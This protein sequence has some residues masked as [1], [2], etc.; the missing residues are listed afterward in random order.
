MILPVVVL[1]VIAYFRTTSGSSTTWFDDFNLTITRGNTELTY[2]ADV[3]SYS[4]YYAFGMQMPGRYANDGYRYGFGGHEKDDEIK[5]SGNHYSFGDYGYDPRLGRRW[6]VDPLANE[7]PGTSPYSY[8][9][10]NPILLK[11]PDGKLPIIPFLLKAGAAG[12]TD[13]LLQ[14]GMNYLLDDDV[15]TIGQAFEKVDWVDVSFSAAQGAL[16]WSVPGGKFGKAAAAATG[17]V[18]LN[19]T[20]AA[21]SG[22]DYSVEQAT[23]DFF[24][25]FF[26]QLTAEGVGELLSSKKA[27]EKLGGIIGQE[28]LDNILHRFDTRS[29]DQ[30]NAGGGFESWGNDMN[31][32]DHATGKN[33]KNKTS[34][35][36]STSMTKEGAV[37]Y[38]GGRKGYLYKIQN[39][40]SGIDV[41]KK[42]G[43][44]SPFPQEQ[45]IV[46]PNK[47]PKENIISSEPL[48]K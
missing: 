27:R 31:L 15:E 29:P 5:G 35:Y 12:A 40:G 38:A 42:L 19:A 17:D 47:I 6:N 16:P 10:N 8:A 28:K 32:M 2:T 7:M 46:I 34:G 21:L 11:D 1:E 37:N 25:G 45:E 30:I 23:A 18:L 20:K 44:K 33:I 3:K 4:D 41:N 36:V 22:E 24:V 14:V 9:Y 43:S 39:P 48:N 13:M 26:S